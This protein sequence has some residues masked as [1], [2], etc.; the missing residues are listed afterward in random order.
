MFFRPDQSPW[1]VFTREFSADFVG[2]I[3]TFNSPLKII[4]VTNV[5]ASDWIL[6]NVNPE[7]R[8]GSRGRIRTYDQSV[9]P[10]CVGTLPL[11]Y[12][13][14]FSRRSLMRRADFQRL[15]SRSRRVALERSGY[16]SVQ[17][18]VHG[19]FLRES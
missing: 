7:R 4:G 10:E 13:F 8:S 6:K 1:P 14:I 17:T 3:V 11:S 18:K 15:I 2:A 16:S 9:N 12:I 5:K 19:P